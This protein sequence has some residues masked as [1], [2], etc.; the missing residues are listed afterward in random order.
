[1]TRSIGR[2][3]RGSPAPCSMLLP[4]L[5]DLQRRFARLSA[6]RV[7]LD[8][9][10]L[11][12]SIAAGA[13][14]SPQHT[15]PISAER[16]RCPHSATIEPAATIQKLQQSLRSMPRQSPP[17]MRSDIVTSGER[18]PMRANH[19]PLLERLRIFQSCSAEQTR[20]FL[21]GKNY[22]FEAD[23]AGTLDTRING[24]Y[25]PDGYLGYVQYGSAA[26]RL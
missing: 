14:W 21:S 10:A 23:K 9:C 20:A 12:C 13:D 6:S 15:E 7:R 16:C 8:I 26:V 17:P 19:E 5:E 11:P 4:H 24:V 18:L 2:Q 25:V 1:M 22:I 3:G